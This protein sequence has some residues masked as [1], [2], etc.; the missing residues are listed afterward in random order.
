[1]KTNRFMLRGYRLNHTTYTDAIWS[2]FTLHN[3]SVNIWSHFLGAALFF[4]IIIFVSWFKQRTI[5]HPW[6]EFGNMCGFDEFSES[7]ADKELDHEVPK[8]KFTKI[9]LII[10]RASLRCLCEFVRDD[11]VLV[12]VPS[13]QLLK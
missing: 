11:G 12:L 5:V 2:I 9:T 6:K 7:H 13:S 3:E 1:M 10:F 4:G 8:C